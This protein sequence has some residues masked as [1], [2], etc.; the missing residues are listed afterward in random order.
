MRRGTTPVINIETDID[1]SD[2]TNLFVSLEQGKEIVVEKTLSDV[3][4][5]EDAVSIHLTQ[6]DTLK[7]TDDKVVRVQLRCT[8]GGEKLASNIMTAEVGEILKGGEI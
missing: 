8:L 1:L 4:I 7:F 6:E 2:A 5:T 3:T